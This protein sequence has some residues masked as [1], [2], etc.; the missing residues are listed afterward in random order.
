MTTPRP[1]RVFLAVDAQNIWRYPI[2]TYRAKI[3]YAK[4]KRY[5]LKRRP[6]F[7]A[8]AYFIDDPLKDQELFFTQLKKIGYD[9]KAKMAYRE[10]GAFQNNDWATSIIED[11]IKYADQYDVFCLVSGRDTFADSITSILNKRKKVEI[12][13]WPE[14]FSSRLIVHATEFDFLDDSC[15]MKDDLRTKNKGEEI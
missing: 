15:L 9:L 1:E 4:L 5:V 10:S 3:D 2:E 12:Y 8:I 13:T 14:G 11:A 7:K 6:L